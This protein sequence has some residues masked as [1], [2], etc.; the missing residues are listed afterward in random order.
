MAELPAAGTTPP[1]GAAPAQGGTPPQ[2][3]QQLIAG[4][5]KSQDELVKAYQESEKKMTQEAQARATLERQLQEEARV[6]EQ[7]IGRVAPPATTTPPQETNYDE[8]FWQKPT[9]VIGRVV[10]RFLSPF[11]EDRYQMQKTRYATDPDFKRYEG[12]IDQMMS[13]QPEL[14]RQPGAV[15]KMYRVLRAL[16]FNPTDL[17]QQLRQKI[18]AEMQNKVAGAVEGAGPPAGGTPQPVQLSAEEQRIAE[19]FYPGIARED[20]YKKYAESKTKWA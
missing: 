15:D 4:K 9:E 1:S 19:K 13:L 8:L 14:K 16:D 2:G 6:R 7:L 20:A 3:D 17:E 5:F 18:V 11:E 10:E 12:Q